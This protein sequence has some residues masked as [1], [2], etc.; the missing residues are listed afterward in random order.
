VATSMSLS[1]V[2]ILTYVKI[3]QPHLL[4]EK[5]QLV[6]RVSLLFGVGASVGLWAIVRQTNVMLFEND[7]G[8]A[9]LGLMS[10]VILLS[11]LV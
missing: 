3:K 4:N 1:L 8:S 5:I 11:S 10:I 6:I 9:V 7:K 2:P